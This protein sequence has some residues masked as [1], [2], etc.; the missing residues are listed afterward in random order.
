MKWSV[1]FGS[2]AGWNVEVLGME[3]GAPRRFGGTT[4]L[5]AASGGLIG[6]NRAGRGG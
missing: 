6:W 5:A 2:W 3:G 1:T 4:L